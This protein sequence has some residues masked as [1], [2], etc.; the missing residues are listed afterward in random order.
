MER[1]DFAIDEVLV[2]PESRTIEGYA[3]VFNS[4]SVDLGGFIER[5]APGAFKR[6]IESAPIIHA[7]WN[8]DSGIPLGSTRS[9]KLA[10]SED[11]NGLHF[12]LDAK[13]LTEAQLDAIADGDMRMS[14]GFSVPSGGDKWEDRAG[15]GYTRTLTDVNLSE[16]SVVSTPAYPDTSAALR[17][18]DIYKQ[19]TQPEDTAGVLRFLARAR[20]D[21][22]IRKS[23]PKR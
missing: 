4:D 3:A 18:L 10:L 6:S 1:R 19:L 20:L 8:H 7:F 12:K 2:A 16:V 5:I 23:A 13:R 11:A 14:F 15:G 17:S 22:A 21:I 9:G